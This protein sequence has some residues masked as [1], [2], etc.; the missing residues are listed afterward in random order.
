MT[1]DDTHRA[2][3]REAVA[4][5]N[6]ATYADP[7]VHE[8]IEEASALKDTA[9]AEKLHKLRVALR[10]LRT[11]LWAYR[12]ILDEQ[13]DNEQRAVLKFLA[14]AAGNTRD[15]DI[16]IGLVE[17]RSDEELLNVF[18]QNRKETADRS[19]ETLLNSDLTKLLREAISEA[20]R[21]LNTSAVRTPLT[22]FA[23]KRV[24]AAQKQLKKRMQH[25]SKT[26]GSD[27]N[28]YH[29][30]RK[31][32]KK[33]RYLIEFFEPLLQKRQRKSLKELKQLQKRFGGLNDVV[34]SRNL[35]TT[36]QGSLPDE[37]S[38]DAALRLL[39]KE[40]KRRLKAASRLL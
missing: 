32:G 26:G 30:V 5:A 1:T 33:V 31:A 36:H 24:S 34:A 14:N 3:E 28:S 40:Q 17:D 18:R 4:E 25:A 6:F 21:E 23:R 38:A 20:N 35:L 27:Y 2:S 7:L 39:K 10:R 8:A 29:D 12:P 22:K 19:R 11:L 37:A 15:W 13:F 9:D 16:L